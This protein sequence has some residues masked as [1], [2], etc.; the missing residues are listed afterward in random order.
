TIDLLGE[1]YEGLLFVNLVDFDSLYGHRRDPQGYAEA[2]AF[3][4]RFVPD[5]MG[6]LGGED[7]LVITADHGNDP[8]HAGTDHTREYV[9][10][11]AWSPAMQ[12]GGSIGVRDSFA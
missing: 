6:R 8:T 10:L 1:P 3:F 4:D 12:A 9:P 5:L 11:V 2:L 7:L